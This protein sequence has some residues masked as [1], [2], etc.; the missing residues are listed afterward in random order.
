M[1]R[2]AKY[3][4]EPYDLSTLEVDNI[5]RLTL[6]RVPSKSRI[7]ELGC[8][9][10]YMTQYMAEKLNCAVTVVDQDAQALQFAQAFAERTVA[11]DLNKPKTWR[12]IQSKGLFEVVLASNVVEHLSDTSF[13]LK[14]I[15]MSLTERGRCIIVVPNIAWWRSRWRLL[16]GFWRYEQYGLFDE[17]HLRFFSLPSLRQSLEN[18]GFHV[19]DEA[20]DPAGGAK[21]FTPLL[22]KFPN[23][24]AYQVVMVAEKISS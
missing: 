9:T 5:D 13:Q 2:K 1:Q 18:S 22:K 6:E 10:G 15:N 20:Y 23:A 8:A 11:G 19:L 14:Q 21:W 7:L 3:D 17:T 16:H 12:E 4:R 24:Y